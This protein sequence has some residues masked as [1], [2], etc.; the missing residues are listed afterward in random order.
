V[1]IRIT[2]KERI[3]RAGQGTRSQIAVSPTHPLLLVAAASVTLFSL[4]GTGILAGWLPGPGVRGA[5]P[6]PITA[7]SAAAPVVSRKGLPAAQEKLRP[8]D[9]LVESATISDQRNAPLPAPVPEAKAI[10]VSHPAPSLAVSPAPSARDTA[11]GSAGGITYAAASTEPAYRVAAPA[12][13]PC[14]ECG[15]VEAVREIAVE[16]KGSGGGAIAGGLL[17]G[18]VAN[19]IGKGSTRSIAT[20]LGAAGGA[21]AGNYI[22]KSLKEGKR[23]EVLVR[24]EDDSTQ[25]FSSDSAPVW[26]S[27][28]RVKLQN[29][30]L[31]RGGGR[32]YGNPGTI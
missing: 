3:M 17:G 23:Y 15:V 30:L 21:Y 31:T 18:L 13:T 9:K 16:P 20:V 7:T 25:T 24:F 28:D 2:H 12:P 1:L 4:A 11:S 19:Q 32:P 14:N 27:G 10:A 6:I 5:T 29:G 26:R 8:V 22:E